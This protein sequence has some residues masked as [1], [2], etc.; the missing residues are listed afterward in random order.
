VW[1]PVSATASPGDRLPRDRRVHLAELAPLQ[2]AH[3]SPPAGST[4]AAH[5]ATLGAIKTTSL[6][7][8]VDEPMTEVGQVAPNPYPP[9]MP[10]A[11]A[12]SD[13]IGDRPARG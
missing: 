7:A 2:H 4:R 8:A 9:A 6:E 5:E 10:P 12:P 1:L 13:N 11:L 3:L